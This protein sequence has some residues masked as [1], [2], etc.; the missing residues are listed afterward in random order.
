MKG[1]LAKTLDNKWVVMYA[2]RTETGY[3]DTHSILLH[4]TDVSKCA[5]AD[6]GTTVYFRE[7]DESG[8]H[9]L[10]K[11]MGWGA[12]ITYAKLIAESEDEEFDT[13]PGFVET[14][15]VQFMNEIHKLTIK[16]PNDAD[17]GKRVRHLFNEE[18]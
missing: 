9:H 6:H 16:Y 2:K 18:I 10:H 12:G 5:D 11:D 1:I 8:E 15:S 3:P 7:V 13:K 17:L 14:R 4:P